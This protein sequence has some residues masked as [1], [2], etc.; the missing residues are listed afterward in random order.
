MTVE[1]DG[2]AVAVAGWK[3]KEKQ[4]RCKDEGCLRALRGAA[5]EANEAQGIESGLRGG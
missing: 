1:G 5:S 4:G 3:D 2:S